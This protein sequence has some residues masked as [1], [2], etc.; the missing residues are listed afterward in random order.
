MKDLLTPHAGD[1]P[2][3][4]R[5]GFIH[6]MAILPIAP[7]PPGDGAPSGGSATAAESHMP[8]PFRCTFHFTKPGGLLLCVIVRLALSPPPGDGWCTR[9]F[10]SV[11]L[12]VRVD[13]EAARDAS[14]PVPAPSAPGPLPEAMEPLGFRILHRTDSGQLI[15]ATVLVEPASFPAPAGDWVVRPL[16]DWVV[17]VAHIG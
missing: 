13:S 14:S 4:G 5:F 8:I 3:I 9:R 6:S 15:E 7:P 2:A 16:G 11:H 10:G 1:G 17:R 12:S